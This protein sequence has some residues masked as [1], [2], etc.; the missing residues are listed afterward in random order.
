MLVTFQFKLQTDAAQ[1]EQLRLATLTR[2]QA[3]NWLV[4]ECYKLKMTKRN[5]VHLLFYKELR[6]LFGLS[7]QEAI[8]VIAKAAEVL[9]RDKKKQ[10]YFRAN[11]SIPLDKRLYSI[12]GDVVSIKAL[13]ERLR[14]RLTIGA[15]QQ[16]FWHLEKR[17]ADLV[18]R[19]DGYYLYITMERPEKPQQVPTDCLGVDLGI[20]N[21][22][23][24]SDG[25]QFSGA[26]IENA[27]RRHLTLKSKLQSK[28]HNQKNNKIR[29]K[30][31]RCKLKTLK[32]KQARF[33]KDQNHVISKKLVVSCEGTGRM[34]AMEDLSG[35]RGATVG[36]QQRARHSNWGFHQLRTF[37]TYKAKLAGVITE[38]VDPKNTSRKC[39]HC[40]HTEKANRKSRD[41][42]S[43]KNC[44]T[45]I[46]ADVN[47]AKNIA[48]L[49]LQ[50]ISLKSRNVACN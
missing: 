45:A 23:V 27:R 42:F 25:N 12:K 20:V 39:H 11:S 48:Y 40:G 10:H 49:G 2:N 21:I 18:K 13:E 44:N 19:K 30:Q 29:P 50:S 14:I 28:A 31:V 7:S 38:F 24:D 17:E 47:A 35:I 43:C 36:K 8:Q 41:I 3:T 26:L 4:N 6:E 33:Q 46:N 5:T 32:G 1:E 34:L 16:Q 9:T 15:Y 22:A 37:V